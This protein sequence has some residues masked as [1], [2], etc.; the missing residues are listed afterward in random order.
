MTGTDIGAMRAW[1]H[2]HNDALG[3]EPARLIV[4]A[5]GLVHVLHYLDAARGRN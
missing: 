2:S 4:S 5:E 1:M 3:G